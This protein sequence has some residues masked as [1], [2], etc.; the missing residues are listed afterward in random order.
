MHMLRNENWFVAR[1]PGQ[2]IFLCKTGEEVG[3]GALNPATVF[4]SDREFE[5]GLEHLGVLPAQVVKTPVAM[6]MC[7]QM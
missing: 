1:R 5:A 7:L 2:M 6:D 3:F 4:F